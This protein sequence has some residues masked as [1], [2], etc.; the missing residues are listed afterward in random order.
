V[1][2]TRATRRRIAI[3]AYG[4]AAAVA[5]LAA[6]GWGDPR[7]GVAVA[8]FVAGAVLMLARP[9]IER[10]RRLDFSIPPGGA[11]LAAL[12]VAC[13]AVVVLLRLAQVTAGTDNPPIYVLGAFACWVVSLAAAWA[14]SSVPGRRALASRAV[15]PER[16]AQAGEQSSSRS[17]G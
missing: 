16:A 15:R 4:L 10:R 11:E 9:A 13:V 12:P 3:A 5:L 6:L 7:Q 2:S 17:R 14:L 8:A 1:A